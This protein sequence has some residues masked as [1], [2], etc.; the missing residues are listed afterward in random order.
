MSKHPTDSGTRETTEVSEA[1]QKYK[2]DGRYTYSDYCTWDDELRWELIDG[3]AYAMS[4]PNT[5]HQSISINIL[6]KLG[7]YLEGTPCKV[8]HAPF[9]VR[10]NS[11]ES[12][13]TVV[14]PDIIVVC[15]KS[16]LDSAGCKGTPDMIIEILSRSTSKRDRTI[17]FDIYRKAGV[18]EYWVVDP[19]TKTMAAHVLKDGEYTLRAYTDTDSVPVHV[20]EGCTI[21][22]SK[23]FEY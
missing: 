3:V 19:D 15:D 11:D 6:L 21:D 10:L 23:V 8:F 17:K 2:R 20:L 1:V 13:D 7:T 4:A 14:Q 9:D 16:I 12:D 18:R 5:V 22:L